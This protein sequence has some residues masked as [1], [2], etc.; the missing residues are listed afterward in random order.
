V[1]IN[2]PGQPPS[3]INRLSNDFTC[4]AI[5]SSLPEPK[6]FARLFA[7]QRQSMLCSPPQFHLRY[8]ASSRFQNPHQCDR[9]CSA[10]TKTSIV[11]H[12][13]HC[14]RTV[15]TQLVVNTNGTAATSYLESQL[16][17]I[18]SSQSLPPRFI[19]SN[20]N[21]GVKSGATAK[22]SGAVAIGPPQCKALPNLSPRLCWLPLRCAHDTAATSIPS[23]LWNCSTTNRV[24]SIC[25][26]LGRRKR[27]SISENRY[28]CLRS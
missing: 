8:T 5:E 11:H 19:L 22:V 26:G 9:E 17:I 2:G 18:S 12:Q 16:A 10:S 25:S 6:R 4:I 1:G 15:S 3:I 13:K 28:A 7:M 14:N 24:Q 23:S 21:F 27:S 20:R